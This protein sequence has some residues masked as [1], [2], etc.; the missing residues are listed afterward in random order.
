MIQDG[1]QYTL[2]TVAFWQAVQ[3]YVAERDRQSQAPGE[4]VSAAGRTPLR[5]RIGALLV[6]MGESLRSQERPAT[7]PAKG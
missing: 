2:G 5:V 6:Q 7:A 3:M 1:M 4:A